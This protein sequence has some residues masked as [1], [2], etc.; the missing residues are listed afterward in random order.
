[1]HGVQEDKFSGYFSHCR[2]RASSSFGL[3]SCYFFINERY[4][5][6]P[7][8]DIHWCTN[9][10]EHSPIW[11]Y[12]NFVCMFWAQT[13]FI[14]CELFNSLCNSRS[15]YCSTLNIAPNN[16]FLV[17]IFQVLIL[18]IGLRIHRCLL[19]SFIISH[20]LYCPKSNSELW[21]CHHQSLTNAHAITKDVLFIRFYGTVHLW[22]NF[23]LNHCK[24]FG[25]TLVS[26]VV[27]SWVLNERYTGC[28]WRRWKPI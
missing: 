4:L 21:W 8:N 18:I 13:I 5:T 16:S 14:R 3:Y 9:L 6:N 12:F 24:S 15:I 23:V 26:I 28:K 2:W 20:F 7:V 11:E 1:M 10:L 27:E 25:E 19:K 17:C 22:L